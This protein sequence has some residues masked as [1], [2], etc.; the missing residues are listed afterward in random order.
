M[1]PNLDPD[2]TQILIPRPPSLNPLEKA[3]FDLKAE[4]LAN[5]HTSCLKPIL[6]R[7]QM[8][9]RVRLGLLLF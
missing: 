1:F 8:M 6:D 5:T 7:L 2:I 3:F 4:V 9:Y